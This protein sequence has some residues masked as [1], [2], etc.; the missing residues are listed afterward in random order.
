VSLK[1]VGAV[2]VLAAISHEFRMVLENGTELG[3]LQTPISGWRPG[4][5]LYYID[6][7]YRIVRVVESGNRGVGRSGTFVV[8]PVAADRP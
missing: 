3:V 5:E 1:N 7:R 2:H 4:N 8:A 6:V